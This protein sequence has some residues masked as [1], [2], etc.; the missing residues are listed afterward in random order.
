M[1]LPT[2]AAL[3]TDLGHCTDRDAYTVTIPSRDGTSI[4]IAHAYD[5]LYDVCRYPAG[6]WYG[7]SAPLVALTA[8][9]PAAAAQLAHQLATATFATTEA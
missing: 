2:I 6:A 4:V 8:S 3:L 1:H 9:S 7:D 5:D